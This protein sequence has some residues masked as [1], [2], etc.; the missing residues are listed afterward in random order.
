MNKKQAFLAYLAGFLD[1]DGS[2]YVRLKPNSTYKYDFQ[3]APSVVL[4]QKHTAEEFLN[5]LKNRLQMGY[6]R[7]RNDGII[8]YTIGDRPSIRRLLRMTLPYLRLKKPQARLMIA[9]L[10]LQ[11]EV[12]SAQEFV[13]LAEM[14]DHFGQLNY[15]KKRV[16]HARVVRNHLVKKGVLTP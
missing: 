3:I 16:I 4:F 8:E 14:I 5:D 2:I 11:K 13:K 1:A 10:D 7:H 9:I 12:A 6:L 15:S